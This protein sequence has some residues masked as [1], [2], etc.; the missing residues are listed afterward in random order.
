MKGGHHYRIGLI[1]CYS[2]GPLTVNELD[3]RIRSKEGEGWGAGAGCPGYLFETLK[4]GRYKTQ[5]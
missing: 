3:V 4:K 2:V 1:S 5:T